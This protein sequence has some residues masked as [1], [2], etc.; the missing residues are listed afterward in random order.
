MTREGENE[1]ND[2][3]EEVD[4]VPEGIP[5]GTRW[6]AFVRNSR[7]PLIAVGV[8]LAGCWLFNLPPLWSEN[9]FRGPDYSMS[10]HG[11]DALASSSIYIA[12]V[13]VLICGL[14]TIVAH[15][16]ATLNRM[17][18]G[19]RDIVGFAIALVLGIVLAT[20]GAERVIPGVP[21]PDRAF[22]ILHDSLAV[23]AV[24]MRQG[25]SIIHTWNQ[26]RAVPYAAIQVLYDKAG[27]PTQWDTT[28]AMFVRGTFIHGANRA[29][30]PLKDAY[31]NKYLRVIPAV[32]I[33]STLKGVS[34]VTAAR[35]TL[36][37]LRAPLV[38]GL[39]EY[40]NV[41]D[42]CWSWFLRPEPSGP[43]DVN[44]RNGYGLWSLI[45]AA[46]DGAGIKSPY[47]HVSLRGW[48]AKDH[49]AS[50]SWSDLR[51]VVYSERLFAIAALI[52]AAALA[53]PA[54]AW[55]SATDQ[56][57]NRASYVVWLLLLSIVA[58]CIAWYWEEDKKAFDREVAEPMH[59]SR[60]ALADS[61]VYCELPMKQGRKVIHTWPKG[62]R[63]FVSLSET[64]QIQDLEG[65][66]VGERENRAAFLIPS[67]RLEAVNNVPLIKPMVHVAN[68][69]IAV[70]YATLDTQVSFWIG[71]LEEDAWRVRLIENRRTGVFAMVSGLEENLA[72]DNKSAEESGTKPRKVRE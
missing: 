28:T 15:A 70:R 30:F 10:G 38:D 34:N 12:L 52:L 67:Q 14:A 59:F 31:L 25:I 47:Q 68:D 23:I 27:R 18:D 45:A 40:E 58:E 57:A 17:E 3:P 71:A 56:T 49:Q 21:E 1:G 62:G 64:G 32:D 60:L 69:N 43:A 41:S 9:R 8:S 72:Q 46:Q 53:F 36:D 20:V 22:G 11:P 29:V 7:R 66:F 48:Q 55:L 50:E 13:L 54:L 33:D 61:C 39:E 65:I 37:S 51:R 4:S 24:P 2:Q 42:S 5:S 44:H 35:M 26:D 19:T 16:V 63:P 6:T